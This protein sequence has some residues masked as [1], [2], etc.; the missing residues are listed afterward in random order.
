VTKIDTAAMDEMVTSPASPAAPGKRPTPPGRRLSVQIARVGVLLLFL[1]IWFVA[2]ERRIVSPLLVPSPGDVGE[3][4]WKDLQ[5]VFTGGAMQRHFVVTTL[6]IYYAFAIVAVLGVLLGV[7]IHEI[8]FVNHVIYPYIVAFSAMPRVAFAPLLLIWFGFGMTSKVVIGVII[9]IFPTLVATLAGLEAADDE[10][11][12]LMRAMGASRLETFAKV[13]FWEA[14]PYIFAG[15]QTSV[16]LTTVGVVIGEFSG[17]REGLGVLVMV[18]Q[19]SLNIAG[20]FSAI[21]LLSAVGLFNYYVLQYAR[22]RVV[23]WLGDKGPR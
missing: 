6:E 23:F 18:Y 1:G 12:Q 14:M 17:G 16:V 21:F 10:K 8:K 15:L 19:D 13:R 7:L 5:S 11:L 4:L 9:A 20:Q 3:R 22:K 2:V